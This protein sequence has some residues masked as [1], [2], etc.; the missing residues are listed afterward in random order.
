MKKKECAHPEC[1]WPAH[2][3]ICCGRHKEYEKMLKEEGEKLLR[4]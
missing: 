1:D 2:T 4:K 3:G